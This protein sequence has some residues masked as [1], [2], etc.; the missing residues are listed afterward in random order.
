VLL[1][2]IITS[3]W[4]KSA[5]Y[6]SLG[7]TLTVIGNG[8]AGGDAD[9]IYLGKLDTKGFSKLVVT[10]KNIEGTFP[11]SAVFG[12]SIDDAKV[13]NYDVA[14]RGNFKKCLNKSINDNFIQGKLNVGDKIVFDVSGKASVYLGMKTFIGQGVKYSLDLHLEK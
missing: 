6:S 3:G 9:S 2:P 8:S 1:E 4:G 14:N 10:V 12:L 13:E 11:W 7:N 5:K